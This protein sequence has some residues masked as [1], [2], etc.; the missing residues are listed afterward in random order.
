MQLQIVQVV[1]IGKVAC[2][3]WVRCFLEHQSNLRVM[4]GASNFGRAFGQGVASHTSVSAIEG[5]WLGEDKG[6]AHNPIQCRI[7][8]R[9]NQDPS[10]FISPCKCTGI[11][12]V[13]SNVPYDVFAA[14]PSCLAHPPTRTP[15]APKS[16]FVSSVCASGRTTYC[17]ARTKTM[18]LG[19]AWSKTPHVLFPDMLTHITMPCF[20]TQYAHIAATYAVPALAC[21]HACMVVV[22]H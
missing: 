15:Q 17:Q 7:C 10:V 8:W 21:S 19:G 12:L 13:V 20:F 6:E 11:V 14:T 22:C 4:P 16:T 3:G 2:F 9:E 5:V 18:V 1:A